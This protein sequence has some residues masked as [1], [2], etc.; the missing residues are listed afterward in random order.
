MDFPDQDEIEDMDTSQ[1]IPIEVT[2]EIISTS[3][4]ASP[5]DI[6]SPCPNCDK[7]ISVDCE[8]EPSSP[9]PIEVTPEILPVLTTPKRER[10]STKDVQSPCPH[11][12]KLIHP[13]SMTR[14]IETIH[15]KVRQESQ[16]GKKAPCPHC[17]KLIHV[18][19]LSR[20]IKSIHFN[21][22]EESS[23]GNIEFT[24]KITFSNPIFTN[25]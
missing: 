8:C 14:H 24:P 18:T 2:P 9:I 6:E 7:F 25:S 16:E 23:R 4:G 20:H 10:A 1:S 17:D 12:D 22:K 19:S 5:N 13:N 3:E 11:C 15:L 21:M